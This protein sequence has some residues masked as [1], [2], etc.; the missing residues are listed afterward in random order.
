MGMYNNNNKDMQLTNNE[1]EPREGGQALRLEG[2][3]E[4]DETEM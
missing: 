1:T 4:T 2:K 3:E